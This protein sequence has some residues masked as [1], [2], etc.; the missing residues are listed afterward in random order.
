MVCTF[1][2]E[3]T[4]LC[5]PW[6]PPLFFPCL[7]LSLSLSSSLSILRLHAFLSPSLSLRLSFTLGLSLYL[8]AFASVGSE[9][10]FFSTLRKGRREVRVE[11]FK[12][13]LHFSRVVIREWRERRAEERRRL[14]ERA[15]FKT[16]Q[17]QI[18]A[19]TVRS[20]RFLGDVTKRKFVPTV[21]SIERRAV[22]IL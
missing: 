5:F 13:L 18:G 8:K 20:D 14:S 1:K 2:R 15:L 22:I 19:L 6:H 12:T 10:T 21:F 3:Y 16:L 7:S 4:S 9:G 11:Y 17:L